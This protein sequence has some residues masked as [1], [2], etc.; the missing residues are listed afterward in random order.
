MYLAMLFLSCLSPHQ[1]ESKYLASSGSAAASPFGN[2]ILKSTI[3]CAYLNIL[4]AANMRIHQFASLILLYRV[5]LLLLSFIAFS[6]FSSVT[7]FSNST[8]LNNWFDLRIFEGELVLEMEK[9]QIWAKKEVLLAFVGANPIGWIV[10]LKNFE[11]QEIH[12]FHKLQY[13]FKSMEGVAMHWFY[14][15]SQKNLDSNWES[16][17]TALERRFEDSY[18]SHV[19]GGLTTLKQEQTETEPSSKW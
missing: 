9:M 8:V 18:G 12:S 15:W 5:D 11:V 10:G 19:F 2:K 6:H 16:F 7:A 1:F 4:F 14:F 13:A 3:P 17:S